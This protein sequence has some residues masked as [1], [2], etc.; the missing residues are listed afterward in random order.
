MGP[1]GRADPRIQGVREGAGGRDEWDRWGSFV[2]GGIW[3]NFLAK[4]PESNWM[5]KRM[6]GVSRRVRALDPATCEKAGVDLGHAKTALFRAQ[7]NC[8]YWHGLFGG[9]YLNYLR[10][11]IWQNLVDYVQEADVERIAAAA[12]GEREGN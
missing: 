8:A 3:Q 10:H 7:C 6:L 9:L 5:H 4:Y 2:R 11:A 12:R 1:A